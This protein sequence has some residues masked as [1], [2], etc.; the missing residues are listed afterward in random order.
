[1]NF[2]H[3]ERAN[4]ILSMLDLKPEQFFVGGS[5]G[6]ALRG[7]RD[8]GDIDVGVTTR[9]WIELLR[10]GDWSVWTTNPDDERRRCDPP[11]LMK[12]IGA[13]EINVFHSWRWR[14]HGETDYNDFNLVFR[15][16]IEEIYGW[17]CIKLPILLRQKI[18][19]IRYEPARP[20]DIADIKLISDY[21]AGVYE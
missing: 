19:A 18:D 3:V 1:M 17:P 21:L 12:H 6:L 5:T 10:R 11:Y 7:I 15:D 14:G 20:K 13:T 4:E 9:Y 2:E 8:F 16:G